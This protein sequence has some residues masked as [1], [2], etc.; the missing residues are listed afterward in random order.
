MEDREDFSKK[1]QDLIFTNHAIFEMRRRGLNRKDVMRIASR[2]QQAFE[3]RPG[4][5]VF[6]SKMQEGDKEFL[7]R[8]FIDVDRNPAEIVT[9]YK[10]SKINK[11]WRNTT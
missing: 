1:I 10:T 5:M 3:V 8:V 6:Q 11:Y 4:R 2:P 9:A 7:L